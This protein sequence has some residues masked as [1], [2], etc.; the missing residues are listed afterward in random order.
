MIGV[1]KEDVEADLNQAKKIFST[2]NYCPGVIVCKMILADFGNAIIPGMSEFN[3]GE[4]KSSCDFL[5]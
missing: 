3:L 1:A 5:S 2:G 4:R